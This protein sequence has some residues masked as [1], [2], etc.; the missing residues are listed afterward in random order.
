MIDL[1]IENGKVFV[2][3]KLIEA[4]LRLD[5]GKIVAIEKKSPT[6]SVQETIDATNKIIIPGG[7]D[8]HTH[9]LDLIYSCRDD[10]VTGTQ[11]AASGGITTVLEMPLGINGKTAIESFEMQLEAMQE[12]CIVDYGLIGAAGHNTIDSIQELAKRGVVGFKTFMINAPEEEAELK[13]LAAKNDF[14][15]LKIFSKIAKTGLV[16]SVHAENDGIIAHEIQKQI[17]LDKRDFQAHTD[18]RPAIAEDLACLQAMLLANHANVKLNL[19]HMSSRTAFDRIRRAKAIGWDVTC[20]ITPHHL[21]FTTEEAEKIGPWLKVNPPIRSKEHNVA[22]WKA[23]NDGTIDFIASDHSPYSHEEKDVESKD[24]N[25]FECGSG[26][27]TLETTLPVMLDAVNK[28]KLTL[29][30]LVDAIATRPAKRFCLYPRKGEIRIGADAD[31][32]IID[33]QK[34]YTLR[35]DDMYTKSKI[36]VFNGMKIQGKIEQTIVRG[37]VVFDNGKF[38]V[39]KGYGEYITPNPDYIS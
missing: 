6:T 10:F 25:F 36:T 1:L 35:N 5:K 16:S 30:R 4:N 32:V 7:I 14:F 19:V 37:K 3:N 12:K 18:S 22:A 33:M 39:K 31:L 2:E 15:L 20:E 9:I 29:N 13:D 21:L 23:L 17:K 24:N 28:N 11:G 27:P 38:P 34:E 8:V 26:T